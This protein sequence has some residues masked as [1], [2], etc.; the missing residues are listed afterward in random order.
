MR[1]TGESPIEDVLLVDRYTRSKQGYAFHTTSTPGHL[2]HLVVSGRV[3]QQCNGR[4]YDV[5]HGS[6]VWYHDT[7]LVQGEVTV[8]PWTF[9]T[10]NFIAPTMPPPA[11]NA[12]VRRAPAG[13]ERLFARL[14]QTWNA[15]V[16]AAVRTLQVHGALNDLLGLI[17]STS[18]SPVAP[19]AEPRA[20]LWWSLE[21][22]VRRSLHTLHT[23]SDLAR[24]SGCSAATI[25]RSCVTATGIPPM[26]RLKQLRLDVARGLVQKSSLSLSVIAG[27]VGYGRI[28][29]FSRD[30]HKTFSLAPSRDRELSNRRK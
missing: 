25:S 12:R 27:Q 29:E 4:S 3:K 16:P 28:H 1:S 19:V 18:E 30:Y 23:L 7:E 22:S 24:M 21:T 5:G 17:F 14:Y 20:R 11:D 15:H 13:A 26:R 8:A 2:V 6:L 10:V 9:Y